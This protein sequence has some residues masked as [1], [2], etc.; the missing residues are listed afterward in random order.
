MET[1]I[2]GGLAQLLCHCS[3]A[4]VVKCL[5]KGDAD[6]HVLQVLRHVAVLF[7]HLKGRVVVAARAAFHHGTIGFLNVD[8]GQFGQ[9]GVG[10]HGDG[11]VA[12]HAVVLLAPE[13]PDGQIAV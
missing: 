4:P 10:E 13:V 2:V 9:Y 1:L 8:V 7:P 12:N 3:H 6:T 11:V 5:L